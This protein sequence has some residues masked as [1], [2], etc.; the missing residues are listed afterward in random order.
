MLGNTE[1]QPHF[2]WIGPATKNVEFRCVSN[3]PYKSSSVYFPHVSCSDY[4]GIQWCF[5][6]RNL[7]SLWSLSSKYC[8]VGVYLHLPSLH[9]WNILCLFFCVPNLTCFIPMPIDMLPPM[10]RLMSLCISYTASIHVKM[11][12]R[13]V[14]Y[15]NLTLSMVLFSHMRVVLKSPPSSLSLFDTLFVRKLSSALQSDLACFIIKSSFIT[16]KWKISRFLSYSCV[17]LSSTIIYILV[18]GKDTNPFNALPNISNISSI[19]HFIDISIF[20]SLVMYISSFLRNQA[21]FLSW[22][23]VFQNI[24]PWYLILYPPPWDLPTIAYHGS[25]T[26]K[27]YTICHYL[28]F[29][30]ASIIGIDNTSFI[31]ERLGV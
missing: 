14:A 25:R 26:M 3:F 23:L 8:M 6:F 11:L 1:Y 29:C 13:F 12:V 4:L 17:N 20:F 9:L 7:V 19:C 31:F 5:L 28:F 10:W 22:L 30:Y 27:L 18:A 21:V 24:F 2:C 16:T 15:I